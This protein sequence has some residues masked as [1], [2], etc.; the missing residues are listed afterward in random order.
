MRNSQAFSGG[1]SLVINVNG[2]FKTLVSGGISV[3]THNQNIEVISFFDTVHSVCKQ[4]TFNV[5]D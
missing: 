4:D 2:F 1:M 3:V 5:F